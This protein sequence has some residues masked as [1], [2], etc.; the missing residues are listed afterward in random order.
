MVYIIY[1]VPILFQKIDKNSYKMVNY[2]DTYNE[3]EKHIVEIGI[4]EHNLFIPQILK[5]LYDEEYSGGWYVNMR[6]DD[7]KDCIINKISYEQLELLGERYPEVAKIDNFLKI[8]N[9]AKTYSGLT[10]AIMEDVIKI[11][12]NNKDYYNSIYRFMFSEKFSINYEIYEKP[13]KLF[14]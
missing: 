4:R 11:V 5:C 9:E 13:G 14:L 6:E 1:N 12:L 8:I 7:D 2:F 3:A 10:D